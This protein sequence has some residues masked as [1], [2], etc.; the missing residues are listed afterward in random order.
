[1]RMRQS[2]AQFEAAFHEETAEERARREHLRR[3]AAHRSRKRRQIRI[4][5]GGTVRFSVLMLTIVATTDLGARLLLLGLLGLELL[6]GLVD[7]LPV[8]LGLARVLADLEVDLLAEDG[9]RARGLDPD[10]NLLAHDREDRH[11]DVVPDH[12]ALIGLAR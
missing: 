12:D 1:M 10:A 9:D 3:E 8:L 4:Q 2:L 11:L 5:R 6:E 7:R